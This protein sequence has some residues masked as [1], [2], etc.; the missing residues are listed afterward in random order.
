M[1]L[2]QPLNKAMPSLLTNHTDTACIWLHL[3]PFICSFLLAQVS[4]YLPALQLTQ[5]LVQHG[6][7]VTKSAARHLLLAIC[8]SPSAAHH[9]LPCLAS[10][11]RKTA[12]QHRPAAHDPTSRWA[13]AGCQQPGIFLTTE[14]SYAAAHHLLPCLANRYR[15]TARHTPAVINL[16]EK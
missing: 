3:G 14:Y 6:C 11:Y 8:C 15:K 16:C 7:H 2:I 5:A 1:V 9:L 13:R 12:K 4:C 10:R